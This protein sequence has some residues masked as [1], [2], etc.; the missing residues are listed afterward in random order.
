MII[1]IFYISIHTLCRIKIKELLP[2]D[3]MRIEI[4][5][6]VEFQSDPILML[7]CFVKGGV[8]HENFMCELC[9][10][11]MIINDLSRTHDL[12]EISW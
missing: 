7:L 1:Q 5:K 3:V 2:I 4:T 8:T 12:V 11:Y 9:V 10:L 6:N